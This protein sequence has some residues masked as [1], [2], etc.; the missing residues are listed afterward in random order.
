M[1]WTAVALDFAGGEGG[2]ARG[3]AS[4]RQ[5]FHDA[6]VLFPPAPAGLRDT[7]VFSLVTPL[8]PF[9]HRPGP[10]SLVTCTP[11]R[12]PYPIGF[13]LACAR[14]CVRNSNN[15]RTYV[16]TH[17]H[18]HTHILTFKYTHTLRLPPRGEVSRPNTNMPHAGR[19]VLSVNV[20]LTCHIFYFVIAPSMP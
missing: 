10:L 9:S 11:S 14:I 5:P 16:D 19:R 18:T 6:L 13:P 4:S 20:K 2:R 3:P 7:F 8:C 15:P 12:F 1:Q 17:T